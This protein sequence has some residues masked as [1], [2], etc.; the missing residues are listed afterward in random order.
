M[1]SS[2]T[3]GVLLCDTLHDYLQPQV[4]GDF[5]E[6]LR[7]RIQNVDQQFILK[8]YRVHHNELPSSPSEADVW[9]INGSPNSVYYE[10]DWITRLISF[11]RQVHAAKVPLVGFC[12]GH[13]IIATALGGKVER[14]TQGWGLGIANYPVT[15]PSSWMQPAIDNYHIFVFH[16]DQI[17]NLPAN[18][19]VLSGNEFCP[20]FWLQY[21]DKTM[22]T[23]GHP[24]FY[25]GFL[26]AVLSSDEFDDL[27]EVREQGLNNLQGEAD[28]KIMFQ[29][30]TNFYRQALGLY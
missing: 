16:Q 9:L 8:A 21:D 17:V 5:D 28:T 6:L 13:H 15:Q 30:V 12:F 18:T 19:Q 4:G 22:S 1:S 24:E 3:I 7:Q 29:W 20:Y 27:P 14:S 26:S 23:Q 25:K 11:V 10:L 2:L